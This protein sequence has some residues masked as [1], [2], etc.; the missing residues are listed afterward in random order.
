MNSTYPESGV[1]AVTVYLCPFESYV[2]DTPVLGV[3]VIVQFEV[4]LSAPFKIE[5]TVSQPFKEVS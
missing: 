2:P 3:A 5:I 1:I 4:S